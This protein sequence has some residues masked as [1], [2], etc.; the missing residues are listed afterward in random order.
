[1]IF[2]KSESDCAVKEEP[3]DIVLMKEKTCGIDLKEALMRAV[4]SVKTDCSNDS[5][6]V[7][8]VDCA[9]FPRLLDISVYLSPLFTHML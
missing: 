2:V 1:M 3:L 4:D 9:A 7:V 5:P 6:P 8:L